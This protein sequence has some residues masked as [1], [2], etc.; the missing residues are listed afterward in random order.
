MP[1]QVSKT[2][3]LSARKLGRKY[4]SEHEDDETKGYLP[5]LDDRLRGVEILGEIKLGNHEIPLRK[6]IGTRTAARSNSFAANWMPLLAEDTEFAAKWRNVYASQLQEGIR[7]SIKVYEYINRYYVLEGNK[8]VSILNYVGA[9]SINADVIR[10]IPER[11]E[12]NTEISIYYEFLDYD[13]RLFFDNLW[14]SKKGRFKYLVK[15]SQNFL[16]EHPEIG[17]DIESFIN[18]IHRTFR[19][20]YKRVGLDTPGVTTGDA[21]NVYIDIFGFPWKV[22]ARELQSNIKRM[23]PQLLVAAGMRSRDTVEISDRE[24]APSDK[25]ARA[26]QSTLSV[27]FAFDKTPE[28]YV[29]TRW[30]SVAIDRIERR[31]GSKLITDRAYNV[32]EGPGGIYEDLAALAKKEPAILFATSPTQ[33]AAALRIAL[34]NPSMIVL[35]CDLAREGKNLNTYFCKEYDADFLYG[36]L[37][38]AQSETGILGYMSTASFRHSPTYDINAFALGAKLINPRAK[39]LEFRLKG[40]NDW[41]EHTDGRKYFAENGS[42]MA[43]CRHSPDNP[44]ERKAFPEVFAQIYRLDKKSGYP[45]ESMGAAIFDWEPF[46]DKVISDAIIGRTSLLESQHIGGNPIHFGWGLSTGIMDLFT[47]DQAIGNSTCRLIRT[48]RNLIKQGLLN[49]FEGPVY[50]TKGILRFEHNY[51]PTLIEI[52]RIHWHESSVIADNSSSAGFRGK[53]ERNPSA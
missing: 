16:S 10:L 26:K 38:A 49:P 17:L 5:V 30:H 37:A 13:K 35:N 4:L 50:D 29:W 53:S 9:A 21:L 32:G 28:T 27:A 45:I 42:D 8:R 44:L 14:F 1:D 7:E 15:K 41:Q 18:Q 3:Y 12:S 52:Q 19:A 23:Y 25:K 36:I 51:L 24:I 31:L 47:N 39:V 43:F 46:Y 22:A 6:I 48:F 34:E 33:S 11:D 40:I 20:A 2:A